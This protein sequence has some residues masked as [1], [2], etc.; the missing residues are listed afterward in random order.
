M[1]H[2]QLVFK[3]R[4]ECAS[5]LRQKVCFVKCTCTSTTRLRC[6]DC[7]RPYGVSRPGI[8]PCK[9]PFLL[10]W[11]ASIGKRRHHWKLSLEG[12]KWYTI[13]RHA[14]REFAAIP[15]ILLFIP[16]MLLVA[17]LLIVVLT[18]VLVV[19]LALYFAVFFPI[20]VVSDTITLLSSRDSDPADETVY[21]V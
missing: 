18:I 12:K 13:L 6:F 11:R 20:E 21:C 5:C 15:V 7:H 16:V 17:V 8:C 1:T 4:T 14:L 2:L 19:A 3:G 10:G 9:D